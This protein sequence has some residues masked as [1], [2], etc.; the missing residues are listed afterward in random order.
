MAPGDDVVRPML[1][2][3]ARGDF[4][5]R[6][7]ELHHDVLIV[8]HVS[9]PRFRGH[10]GVRRWAGDLKRAFA[11]WSFEMDELLDT[12][13]GGRLAVGRLHLLGGKRTGEDVHRPGAL[14]FTL[15]EGLIVRIEAFPN[16]VDEAYAAAGLERQAP[17]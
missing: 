14:L 8:S 6:G 4:E 13:A 10:G 1:D 15:K 7:T 16:R 9:G 17:A 2:R 5:P 11:E 3:W 12:P